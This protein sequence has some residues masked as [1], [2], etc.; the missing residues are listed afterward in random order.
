MILDSA[1]LGELMVVN[2]CSA[3]TSAVKVCNGNVHLVSHIAWMAQV[4]T[5]K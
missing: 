5:S 3:A 1:I 2:L 4:L